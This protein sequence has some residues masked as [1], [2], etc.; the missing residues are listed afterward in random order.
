MSRVRARVTMASRV[1]DVAP[2]NIYGPLGMEPVQATVIETSR[3]TSEL[4]AITLEFDCPDKFLGLDGIADKFSL[5]VRDGVLTIKGSE[6]VN[7]LMRS[8]DE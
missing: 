2:I 3:I 4:V 7:P 6:P 1:D 5:V 8:V